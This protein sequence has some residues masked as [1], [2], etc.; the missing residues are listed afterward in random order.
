MAAVTGPLDRLVPDLFRALDA[1]TPL[2]VRSPDAMRPWQHV[3]EPVSGYLLLAEA[4]CAEGDAFAESWNFGPA[5]GRCAH[6]CAGSSSTC[7]SRRAGIAWNLDSR[8]QPHETHSLT[9][10]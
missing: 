2:R 7:V 8:P 3:L 10:G 5:D 9:A 6:A 4:L 1:S